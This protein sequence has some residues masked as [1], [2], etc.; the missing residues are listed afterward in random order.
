MRSIIE[1]TSSKLSIASSCA[2]VARRSRLGSIDCGRV[3]GSHLN[4]LPSFVLA[5]YCP[6]SCTVAQ[7]SPS[8]YSPRPIPHCTAARFIEFDNPPFTGSTSL[9]SA[10]SHFVT[11]SLEPSERVTRTE[12][13]HTTPPAGPSLKTFCQLARPTT[14][15][16]R[17]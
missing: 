17:S 15:S 12:R 4:H 2:F 9:F 8:E 14:S 1:T 11:H 6:L 5:E 13:P 7:D 10:P 3:G 16:R